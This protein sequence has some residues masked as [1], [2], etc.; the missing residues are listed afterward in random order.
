MKYNQFLKFIAFELT[1]RDLIYI[2]NYLMY[3]QDLFEALKHEDVLKIYIADTVDH[4]LGNKISKIAKMLK[5]ELNVLQ[6]PG[7][8]TP[9]DWIEEFFQG[10]IHL[11]QTK[12]YVAQ[13]KRLKILL[14]KEGHPIGGKWSFDEENRK[15]LPLIFAYKICLNSNKAN[16]FKKL[17]TT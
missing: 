8:L 7:F 14:D 1:T 16:T 6:S 5:A 11:S 13:R 3:Q 15:K 17:R 12:F 10:A 2:V 9:I 4:I